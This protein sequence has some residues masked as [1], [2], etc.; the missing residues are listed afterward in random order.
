MNRDRRRADQVLTTS[1]LRETNQRR[2]YAGSRFTLSL[3]P[4]LRMQ[5]TGCIVASSRRSD[6]RRRRSHCRFRRRG[7]GLDVGH[8]ATVAYR[9]RSIFLKS[10]AEAPSQ[11]LPER[12]C[13]VRTDVLAVGRVTTQGAHYGKRRSKRFRCADDAD[14]EPTCVPNGNRIGTSCCATRN[15][16]HDVWGRNDHP[17]LGDLPSCV[18]QTLPPPAPDSCPTLRLFVPPTAGDVRREATSAVRT[19]ADS[20]SAGRW[21]SIAACRTGG[22]SRRRCGRNRFPPR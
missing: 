9:L 18:T 12:M 2:S 5:P 4:H 19:A 21:R 7:Q 15:P 6:R 8:V 16:P 3:V 20:G 17:C 22:R 11:T 1:R 14:D 13:L 10:G